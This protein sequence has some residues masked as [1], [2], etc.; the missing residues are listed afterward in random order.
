[1]RSFYYMRRLYKYLFLIGLVFYSVAGYSQGAVSDTVLADELILKANAKL[2]D[3]EHDSAE[4]FAE[5]GLR[6]SRRVFY[7]VGKAEA[8]LVMAEVEIYRGDLITA[9]R[10][11]FGALKEYQML[12]DTL[13]IAFVNLQI[14]TLFEQAEL[15]GKALEYF[16]KAENLIKD[17][18]PETEKAEI[19]EQIADAYVGLENYGAPLDYYYRLLEIFETKNDIEG[20]KRVLS[21]LIVSYNSQ[22]DYAQSLRY[23]LDLLK[24]YEASDDKEQE[25]VCLNNIGYI[26]KYLY[27]FDQSLLYFT[28]ALEVEEELSG[29]MINPVTMVNMA[30]VNQNLGNYGESLD[31]LMKVRD[32][33]AESGNENELAR[34][35]NLIAMVHYN[36]QDYHNASVYNRQATE[37]AA[38]SGNDETLKSCYLT[39]S[40]ID[41]E[42]YNYEKSLEN[43]R[44]Y[45]QLS[46]SIDSL[47]RENKREM[48]QQQ[49]VVEKTVKEI[50]LLLLDDEIRDREM[51][52]MRLQAEAREQQL[53][54]LRTNNELQQVTI[55]NQN[56][57]KNRAL[58]DKLLAEE[59]LK[60]VEMEQERDS[61]IYREQ[62]QTLELREA[63]R[64]QEINQQEIQL[65]TQE[66][67]YQQ[68]QL[69]KAR[70]RNLFMVGISVLVLL[71]LLAVYRGLRFAKKANK[72]LAKQKEEIK[73][74]LL[75]IDH[76]RKRSDK[77]LLNILPVETADELKE[78]GSATPKHYDKVSVLFTDFVGFT[79]IA[80]R[81]TPEEL[82][83]ELNKAFLAFDEI[84]DK[85]NLEK[86]KTIGD[87][88]MCA[89]GIPVSNETN[90][91]DIVHA[92]LE[93]QQL[94]EEMKKEK[95]LQNEPYWEIRLGI[96]TGPVVAGVVGK[97]K[98]AYDI[99][100][101]AVN[102]ASRME[103]SGKSG[104]VNI[105]GETYEL[106][107]SHFDCTYRGKVLAKNKGEIDMYFV[108]GKKS[109]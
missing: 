44:N 88:Y 32:Q 1:V 34:L 80:A 3:F 63:E 97:N 17:E 70:S 98:F 99:W 38:E 37:M 33:L 109:F 96:H 7:R 82:V 4:Y 100:G 108:E 43:F 57:E 52:Q 27:D 30:I 47:E 78:K 58:Q 92:G 104:K 41:E 81:L 40:L 83:L 2:F 102:T 22:S 18:I 59:Q 61:L 87:A 8:Q 107:K 45:L 36:L 62:I 106:V 95:E 65:L 72:K 67:E 69:S 66:Q 48:I 24:L 46:N 20:T 85:Y 101:D 73:S 35:D 31:L 39:A 12:G 91:V 28:K 16:I 15:Y 13:N 105:S 23:N 50:E 68:L 49:F 21:K 54:I 76:E 5:Q 55:V 64:V 51:Q 26:Y 77:L 75:V 94:M 60:N 56:L 11:Y 89:G 53:E 84:I 19:Y 29:D 74:N 14:G 86:I 42:L 25:V 71:V 9:V 93:I 79:H 90:P 10:N 6:K 103:S